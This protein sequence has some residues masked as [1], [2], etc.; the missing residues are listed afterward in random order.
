MV[1]ASAKRKSYTDVEKQAAVVAAM[2]EGIK[3]AAARLGIPYQTIQGWYHG[4]RAWRVKAFIEQ[5]NGRIADAFESLAWELMTQAREGIEEASTKELVQASGVCV[6]KMR[7]LRGQATAINQNDNTHTPIGS[8]AF[9]PSKLA[10]E[11]RQVLLE[12]M[13]KMRRNDESIPR[14][15]ADGSGATSVPGEGVR[16]PGGAGSAVVVCEARVEVGTQPVDT[17]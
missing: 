17:P 2:G 13:K 10:P 5:N 6:D 3:P 11:E 12:L 15:V 14:P 1:K 7:L 9:D 8:G 16:E 4:N